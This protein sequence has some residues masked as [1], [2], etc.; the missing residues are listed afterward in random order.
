MWRIV[1]IIVL[2]ACVLIFITEFFIPVLTDKPIF[3]SFRKQIKKGSDFNSSTQDQFE[4]EEN[5]ASNEMRQKYKKR[6]SSSKT[7]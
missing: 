5:K 2:I 4:D 3:G 1:E 7:K 6:N